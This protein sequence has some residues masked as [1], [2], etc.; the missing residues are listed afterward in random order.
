MSQGVGVGTDGTEGPLDICKISLR[1]VFWSAVSPIQGP[2][3]P[4]EIIVMQLESLCRNLRLANLKVQNGGIWCDS[5]DIDGVKVIWVLA[6][7]GPCDYCAALLD[8]VRTCIGDARSVVIWQGGRREHR[9]S[10]TGEVGHFDCYY[11][12]PG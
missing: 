9:D 11:F 1:D 7:A 5:N 6:A 12:K 4:S 2:A 10:M 8:R 3:C